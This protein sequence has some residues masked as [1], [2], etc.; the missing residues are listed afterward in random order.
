MP[1][2]HNVEIGF[3]IESDLDQL[4]RLRCQLCRDKASVSIYELRTKRSVVLCASCA[5]YSVTS[6]R[7]RK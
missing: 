7:G 4:Q 5:G 2:P 3:R 1:D 6:W